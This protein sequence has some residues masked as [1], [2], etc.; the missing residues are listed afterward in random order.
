MTSVSVFITA[1]LDYARQGLPVFP[2]AARGKQPACARGFH[3]A[4]TN[5]A[6]IA[7]YW[8]QADCNIGIPTGAASGIWVL[9]IDGDAGEASLAAL[10]AKHGRVPP[11]RTVITG[12]GRHLWFRYTGPIPSTAARIGLGLDTRGDGGFIVAPPSVH[13]N[14]RRYEFLS[15]DQLADAP[16]WLVQLARTRPQSISERAVAQIRTSLHREVSSSGAYGR[17]ALDREIEALAA[18]LPGT[19]NDALNR[20]AFRLYQLVAGGELEGDQV[21]ERLVAASHRNGLVKDDGI[22]SVFATIAS[23]R[24]GL[25]FPRSRA[26]GA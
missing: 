9:D 6:T 4:T 10:E 2:V 22:A 16:Q 11:T 12:G 26:G 1:A 14:G 15:Y 25:N 23:A 3:A 20:C 18:T 21:T 7:R 5:P 13:P 17:A 19:R 8:R 24:A